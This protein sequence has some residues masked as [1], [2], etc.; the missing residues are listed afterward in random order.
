[1]DGPFRLAF[2]GVPEDDRGTV[3]RQVS[4]GI[5]APLASSMGRLFDAAAAV[6]GLRNRCTYE[7][8][9]A[10]EL[11]AAARYRYSQ[12]GQPDVA[13]AALEDPHLPFPAGRDESGVFI[14][15][16]LPL[17]SALGEGRQ[18]GL[19]LDLLAREFHRAIAG[20]SANLAATVCQEEGLSS[21]A[22]GGGVF[23]NA[24]LL[25]TLK[26]MLEQ[27][28]LRVLVP[29]LLSPND[30]AIAYGQAAVATARLRIRKE[31]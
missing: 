7:G 4:T 28:G 31:E 13:M 30:G 29:R 20:A 16:P 10:M 24:L 15:D 1:M 23:Q 8:E 12:D 25:R 19:P 3:A 14:L 26:T 22:L 9:A 21:V 6:I 5:N 27:R 17:L 11:E 18:R 2:A